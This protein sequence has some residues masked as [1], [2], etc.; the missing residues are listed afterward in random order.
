MKPPNKKIITKIKAPKVDA[1]T[2]V[3]KIEARKRHMDVDASCRANSRSNCEKN[4]NP[5]AENEF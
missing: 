5:Y 4:L 3:W 1:A 2:M